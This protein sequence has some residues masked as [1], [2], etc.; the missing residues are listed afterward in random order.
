MQ[1][2]THTKF[3]NRTGGRYER[4]PVKASESIRK[5]DLLK[6]DASTGK[7]EQLLALA[8]AGAAT[9]S[10]GNATI[11]AI[12]DEDF[13]ADG[14]GVSTDGQSRTTIGVYVITDT[15]HWETRGYNATASNCQQQD[16]K[17]G[18]AYLTQRWTD[19]NGN[20]WYEVNTTT[21]NGEWMKTSE[22][23]NS[24]PTDNYGISIF[25]PI[26]SAT[27]RQAQ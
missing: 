13:I 4:P 10:S 16:F 18:T 6:I 8:S 23:P 17:A 25:K 21:A 27:V 12:A 26:L 1:P 20:W 19:D 14:S 24:N 2:A 7:V 9:A 22:S 5:G 11:W 15:F 3:F